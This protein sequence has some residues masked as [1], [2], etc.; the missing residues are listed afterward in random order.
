[1]A[2]YF[3]LFWSRG[4]FVF[5]DRAIKD[6]IAFFLFSASFHCQLVACPIRLGN[7]WNEQ[8]KCMCLAII[9]GRRPLPSGVLTGGFFSI[10]SPPMFAILLWRCSAQSVLVITKI[11]AP[12]TLSFTRGNTTLQHIPEICPFLCMFAKVVILSLQHISATS[13]CT[14]PSR[15][16]TRDFV[17]PT[18]PYNM[19]PPVF[20]RFHAIYRCTT[21]V[22]ATMRYKQIYYA[23][24]SYTTQLTTT[25]C[26][27]QQHYRCWQLQYCC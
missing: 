7:L 5:S 8:S 2:S 23:V 17:A 4:S 11:D 18:C 22:T 15:C 25:L 1:M 21:E 9:P 20:C 12:C 16:T 27:L 10:D 19:T 24:N 26:W 13:P 3:C 6:G 14:C